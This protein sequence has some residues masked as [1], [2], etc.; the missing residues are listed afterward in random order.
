MAAITVPS[1][2]VYALL[3]PPCADRNLEYSFSSGYLHRASRKMR[4]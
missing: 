2:A 1:S 4:G 3:M